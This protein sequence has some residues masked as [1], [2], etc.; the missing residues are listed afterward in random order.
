MGGLGLSVISLVIFI[1]LRR[2]ITGKSRG[3]G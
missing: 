3:V 1:P 2:A